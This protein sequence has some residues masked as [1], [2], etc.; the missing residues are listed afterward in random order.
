M[1]ET[2][3]LIKELSCPFHNVKIQQG[4]IYEPGAG[5]H[6]KQNLLVS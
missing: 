2:N 6:Q 3:A 1:N 4:T 5:S